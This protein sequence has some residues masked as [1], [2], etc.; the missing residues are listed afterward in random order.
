MRNGIEG[1]RACR[2]RG[3]RRWVGWWSEWTSRRRN[4]K[5][6]LLR[7]R[8]LSEAYRSKIAGKQIW[9]PACGFHPAILHWQIRQF[10]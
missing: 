4:G 6:E 9:K 5:R 1:Y 7:S 8:K 10:L 3:A 2:L